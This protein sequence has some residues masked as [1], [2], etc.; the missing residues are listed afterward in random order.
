MKEVVVIIRV[1]FSSQPQ[2]GTRRVNRLGKKYALEGETAN[3]DKTQTTIGSGLIINREGY[4]FTCSHIIS[5][6]FHTVF[7][8]FEHVRE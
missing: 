8:C 4:I 1:V 5:E 7:F 2:D 6:R 3:L